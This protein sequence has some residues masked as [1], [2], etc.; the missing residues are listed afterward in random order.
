MPVRKSV[1]GSE[2]ERELFTAISTQWGIAS[3]ITPR[4]MACSAFVSFRSIS[5]RLRWTRSRSVSLES[6]LTGSG[7]GSRE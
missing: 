5:A 7:T 3:P 2:N 1:F 4:R 6:C